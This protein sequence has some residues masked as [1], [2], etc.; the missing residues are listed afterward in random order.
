[1]VERQR[2][3]NRALGDLMQERVHA[4][5]IKASAPGE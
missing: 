2:M 3:V 5:Q 1:R 4:M